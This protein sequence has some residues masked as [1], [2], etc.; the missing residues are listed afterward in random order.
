MPVCQN[1]NIHETLML[2]LFVNIC[3]PS[4]DTGLIECK[5]LTSFAEMTQNNVNV[6]NFLLIQ[7]LLPFLNITLSVLLISILVIKRVD[8]N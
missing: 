1:E 8:T 5:S 3:Q 2:T 4:D 7:R 6:L